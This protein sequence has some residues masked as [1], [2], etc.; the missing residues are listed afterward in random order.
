M[1]EAVKDSSF[2]I[3]RVLVSLS[4]GTLQIWKVEVPGH[5]SRTEAKPQNPKDFEV[6][7]RVG[8]TLAT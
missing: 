3:L 4:T 2:A 6:V 5:R 7:R 8:H 1:C